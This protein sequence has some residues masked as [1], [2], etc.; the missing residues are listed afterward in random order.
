MVNILT[1]LKKIAIHLPLPQ[2]HYSVKSVL[3]IRAYMALQH[4]GDI[5]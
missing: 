1:G 5:F 3:A 2:S 4:L